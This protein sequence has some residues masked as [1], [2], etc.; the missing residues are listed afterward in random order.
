MAELKPISELPRLQPCVSRE[1]AAA[2]YALWWLS[3]NIDFS[4]GDSGCWTWKGSKTKKGYGTMHFKHYEGFGAVVLAHRAVYSICVGTIHAGMSILHK[5][6]NPP[7]CR[8]DHLF[9]GTDADNADDKVSKGRQARGQAVRKNH[10]H[11]KGEVIATARLSAL[12]VMEIRRADAAG[13]SPRAIAKRYEMSSTEIAM[14]V[15]GKVWKHLPL[16]YDGDRHNRPCPRCQK[17][18]PT[19]AG[20][21][22]RHV[23]EC[24]SVESDAIL[25]LR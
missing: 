3:E 21:F 18:L 1:G 16:L 20:I 4:G 12:E 24:R 9:Q 10:S 14:I 23:K 13:E 19:R 15:S 22:Y 7:C 6:D 5:C 8:P 17:V 25:G 11:L 2:A